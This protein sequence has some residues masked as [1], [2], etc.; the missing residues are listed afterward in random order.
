MGEKLEEHIIIHRNGFDHLEEVYRLNR[1]IFGEDRL[2]NRLDHDPLLFLTAHCE[3]QLAGFK[4]GYALNRNIFYSAKGATAPLFRK[5]GIATQLLFAMISD[6]MELG[7][8]EMQYDTFPRLYPG[9]TILGLR[10]GFRIR[11]MGWN[12]EY[13]DFQ[14]RLGR[15]I[16]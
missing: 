10:N 12:E 7:F 3:G 16:R 2:I 15:I 9:M 13:N 1:L 4:I 14:M 5:R 6:A 11:R 8:R